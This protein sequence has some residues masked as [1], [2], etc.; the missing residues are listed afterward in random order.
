MPYPALPEKRPLLLVSVVLAVACAFVWGEDTPEVYR[1]VLR[2]APLLMLA[3]YALVGRSDPDARPLAGML[4]LA[5][6]GSAFAD[7]S[8]LIGLNARLLGYLIGLGLFLRHRRVIMD[9]ASRVAAAALFLGTPVL[10]FVAADRAGVGVP[11]FMGLALGGM[12]ASAWISTFPRWRVG[13]GAGLIALS[14]VLAI[15]ASGDSTHAAEIGTWPL[16]YIGH[17]LLTIGVIAELA[18]REYD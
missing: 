2:A 6:V 7:Y 10:L 3:A 17:L 12:A 15:A 4:V 18:A 16:F 5:A 9:S 14:E 11:V 13:L 8:P 1:M